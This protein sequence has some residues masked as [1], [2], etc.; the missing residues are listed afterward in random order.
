MKKNRL[1]QQI[2][3]QRK[4]VITEYLLKNGWLKKR[5]GKRKPQ[6]SFYSSLLLLYQSY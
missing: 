4:N 5:N 2:E 1:Q 3:K 6:E